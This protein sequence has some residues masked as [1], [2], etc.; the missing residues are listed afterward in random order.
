[1]RRWEPWAPPTTSGRNGFGIR[2]RR[3]VMAHRYGREFAE[4][5]LEV[6]LSLVE[7]G[8]CIASISQYQRCTIRRQPIV[9]VLALGDSA[10]WGDQPEQ[11]ITATPHSDEPLQRLQRLLAPRVPCRHRGRLPA[12]MRLHRLKRSSAARHPDSQA[13]AP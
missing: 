2:E 1:M 3:N 8:R 9:D 5:A 10:E 11:S 13:H 4:Q 7:D 12:P 6:L